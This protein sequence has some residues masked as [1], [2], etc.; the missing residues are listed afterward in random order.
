MSL[1]HR[2]SLHGT[3]PRKAPTAGQDI[4]SSV[5]L[6][7]LSLTLLPVSIVVIVI[8]VARQRLWPA[9]D[10]IQAS[11]EKRLEKCVLISGGRMSKGLM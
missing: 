4:L 10:P 11:D 9:D 1:T 7:L 3:M 6:P 2:P 8:S 5:I